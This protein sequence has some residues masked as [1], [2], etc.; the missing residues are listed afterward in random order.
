M[1]GFW[2]RKAGVTGWS[3]RPEGHPNTARSPSWAPQDLN[4]AG[5]L[6]QLES[7]ELLGGRVPADVK[8]ERGGLGASSLVGRMPGSGRWQEQMCG[9][10]RGSG[11]MVDATLKRGVIACPAK[12]L[13]WPRSH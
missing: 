2:G 3:S 9:G 1:N 13:S 7:S 4:R 12:L 8:A 5:F 6:Q 11:S 10:A